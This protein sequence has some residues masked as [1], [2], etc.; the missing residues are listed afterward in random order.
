MAALFSRGADYL[1]STTSGDT[2]QEATDPP[3][4]CSPP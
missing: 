2:T 4:A 1:I 3:Q